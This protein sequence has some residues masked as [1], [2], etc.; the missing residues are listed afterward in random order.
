MAANIKAHYIHFTLKVFK[1]N[2]FDVAL[3]PISAASIY[4]L[5]HIF[6]Q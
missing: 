6:N 1:G 3:M 2:I 5:A 4:L